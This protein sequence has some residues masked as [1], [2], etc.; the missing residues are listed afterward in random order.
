MDVTAWLWISLCGA[1][2]ADGFLVDLLEGLFYPLLNLLTLFVKVLELAQVFG[3]R[4]FLRRDSQLLLDSLGHELA[5]RNAAF[6]SHRLG[7]TEEKIRDFEG[8]LHWPILPYLWEMLFSR[9][10]SQLQIYALGGKRR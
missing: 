1:E 8:R 3:P 7:P 2:F 10:V 5:Q 6:G 9:C 4:F